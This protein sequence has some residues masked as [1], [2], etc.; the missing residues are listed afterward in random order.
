MRS[1]SGPDNLLLAGFLIINHRVASVAILDLSTSNGTLSGTSNI[2]ERCYTSWQGGSVSGG[3][4]AVGLTR[5]GDLLVCKGGNRHAFAGV[6]DGYGTE[7][8]L[9]GE[10]EEGVLVQVPRLADVGRE[11]SM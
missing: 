10:V 8:A 1:R 6:F 4:V 3:K 2:L 9:A 11:S 5:C 7:A